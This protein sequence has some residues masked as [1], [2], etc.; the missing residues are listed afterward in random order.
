[1][2]SLSTGGVCLMGVNPLGRNDAI[3]IAWGLHFSGFL[4]AYHALIQGLLD[5]IRGLRLSGFL[6]GFRHERYRR[7]EQCSL[8]SVLRLG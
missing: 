1:M 8:T 7:S 4:S 5:R 6:S 3:A 2:T